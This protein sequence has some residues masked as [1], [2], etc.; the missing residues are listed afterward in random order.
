M[1]FNKAD[2]EFFEMLFNH[3]FEIDKTN[4]NKNVVLFFGDENDIIK[5][6][7]KLN[8][9]SEE[10]V[11]ILLIVNDSRYDDKLKFV[12]YIPD[13]NAI[14]NF[15]K[16]KK[17][18]LPEDQIPAFC[19][20]VLVNYI[21][22]KLLRIDMYYNQ[23]GYNLNMI[24]PMNETYLRIK[25]YLTVALVGSSGCGKST[26]VNL[27]FNELVARTSS[28]IKDVTSKCSEYYLPIKETKEENIGQIRFL[29][30]PRNNRK[31]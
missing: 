12:N 3:I 14:K 28:S 9:K 4:K 19:E 25:E 15:L 21:N 10:T 29:D 31:L 7:D 26:L 11:P 8:N 20:S 16:A 1:F 18:K 30:F 22:T 2:E 17:E 24:N 6:V 27:I 5:S 13:L 23:L